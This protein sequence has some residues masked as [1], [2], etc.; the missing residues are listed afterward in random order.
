MDSGRKNLDAAVTKLEANIIDDDRGFAALENDWRDLL[1]ESEADN[2]FLTWEWVSAWW[3]V[4]KSEKSL[5]VVV[6]R[7]GLK[8]VGIAPFYIRRT[9]Y[10]GVI[11]VKALMFLGTGES[12]RSEYQ[13]LIAKPK[14]EE[15][16]AR[17]FVFHLK[18]QKNWDIAVF[19][20]LRGPSFLVRRVEDYSE[21][22]KLPYSS[23]SIDD[24]FAVKLCGSYPDY[25]K[26]LSI[27]LRR[28]INN[29]RRKLN[30][31]Y[32]VEFNLLKN[33]N[34]LPQYL[35]TLKELHQQRMRQK[36]I[37]G[38]FSD[39][40][41]EKFHRSIAERFFNS[42]RLLLAFL[43]LDD[44]P[45]AARYGFIYNNKIFD[46]QSGFSPQ[47]AREGVMQVLVSRLI[48]F[49]IASGLSEFDFLGGKEDYKSGF[50]NFS[51]RIFSFTVFNHTLPG[52]IS[53]LANR[54]R[55]LSRM[56]GKRRDWPSIISRR[57]YSIKTYRFY[58]RAVPGNKKHL[59][60]SPDIAVKQ[61]AAGDD[62]LI[63]SIAGLK[64]HGNNRFILDRLRTG[65][66]CLAA[67]VSGR[68]VAFIWIDPDR[69]H[70]AGEAAGGKLEAGTA[71]VYDCLT[72][73]HWRGMYIYPFLLDHAARFLLPDNFTKMLMLINLKNLSAIKAAAKAGFQ[74]EK[75][76]Y[77]VKR[78]MGIFEKTSRVS[79]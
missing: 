72:S 26:S 20:D 78:V 43:R 49:G 79:F 27:K 47:F 6:F 38:K 61:V 54:T 22:F 62:D 29:R 41:Y 28:N 66:L 70:L 37:S 73:F 71:F 18:T 64:G 21:Q 58:G 74:A 9:R 12:V 46:Y 51:R 2:I 39:P 1:A 75:D 57:I 44:R 23:W 48:E 53:S 17:A 55:R 11:P 77:K 32:A 45:V 13:D 15:N 40:N 14:F 68:A 19:K 25:L 63:A 31:R 69:Y 67:V 60:I 65:H 24:C 5:H 36:K 33:K 10:Y 7:D 50:A 4:F 16:V 56:I 76:G 42:E 3:K 34:N 52:G 30:N 35:N 8:P 59:R